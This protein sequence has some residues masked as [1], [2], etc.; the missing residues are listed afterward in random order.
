MKYAYETKNM[1]KA[2]VGS[3]KRLSLDQNEKRLNILNVLLWLFVS[4]LTHV[5]GQKYIGALPL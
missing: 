2:L 5:A 4:V 3:C 1:A